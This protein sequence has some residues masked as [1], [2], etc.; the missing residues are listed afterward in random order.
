MMSPLHDIPHDISHDISHNVSHTTHPKDAFGIWIN[1][2]IFPITRYNQKF[3]QIIFEPNN[4]FGDDNPVIISLKDDRKHKVLGYSVQ[5]SL[6]LQVIIDLYLSQ[7]PIYYESMVAF[8]YC[9]TDRFDLRDWYIFTLDPATA[10]DH[11]DAIS[12]RTIDSK[13]YEVGVHIVDITSYYDEMSI[14]DRVAKQRMTTIYLPNETRHMHLGR[15]TDYDLSTSK[16]RK[17]I[18]ILFEVNR[19]NFEIIGYNII[20]SLINIK[21]SGSYESHKHPFE[22]NKALTW[23]ISFS[24]HRKQFKNINIKRSELVF[25][26]DKFFL[27]PQSNAAMVVEELAIL[28]NSTVGTILANTPLKIPKIFRKHPAPMRYLNDHDIIPKECQNELLLQSMKAAMY[29]V[30]SD[31]SHFHYGLSQEHYTHFTSPIRRYIDVIVHRSL[32]AALFTK[33]EISYVDQ[34]YLY[35]V[36]NHNRH[37]RHLKNHIKSVMIRN[38]LLGK[39]PI[40]TYAYVLKLK[41]NGIMQLYVPSM[42][43]TFNTIADT[44][45]S[46]YSKVYVSISSTLRSLE[47]E[48]TIY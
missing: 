28:A 39:D 36:N 19:K 5:K 25:C 6:C 46:L 3:A 12:F 17:C 7:Y 34:K 23:L 16:D 35:L 4:P 15:P 31:D 45:L 32:I 27:V 13:R 21:Y 2:W 11:D 26:N 37:L 44:K 42:E 18:S 30:K 14:I 8:S 38:A 24:N 10:K 1:S 22:V 47:P 48:I 40:N 43:K 33:T 41:N 9:K 29:V 20:R